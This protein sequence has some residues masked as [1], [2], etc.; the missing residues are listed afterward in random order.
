[1]DQDLGEADYSPVLVVLHKTGSLLVIMVHG[2]HQSSAPKT[3]VGLWILGVEPS[4]QIG[5]V[6]IPGCLSGYDVVAHIP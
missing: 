6:Q 3:D 5:S 4:H 2:I 1:M